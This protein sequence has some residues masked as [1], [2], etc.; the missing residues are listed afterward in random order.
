MGIGKTLEEAMYKGLTAAGYKLE[1]GG[2]VLFTVRDDDKPEIVEVAKRY[3]VLGFTIYAT[4]GTGAVLSRAGLQPIV[5]HKINEA[6]DNVIT[7]MESGKARYVVSTSKR[8]RDPARES[9]QL[10]ALATRL[11]IPCLTSIDT[12]MAV[13]DSLKSR[14]SEQNIELVN[15]NDMRGERK[16]LRFSKMHSCGKDDLY[17]DCLGGTGQSISSPESLSIMLVDRNYGVGGH[18]VVLICDSRI[19]DARMRLFNTDG[20]EGLMSASAVACVG[21]HLYEKGLVRNPKSI[22]V[23][24]QSGVRRLALN[25][26][27]GVAVSG[28]VNLGTPNFSPQS[29][30]VNLPGEKILGRVVDTGDG[31][32]SITCVSMGSPHCV[33]FCDDVENARVEAIGPK[34]ELAPIFPKRSNVEFVQVLDEN[35]LKMR[36]WERG[37]G[38]T[39]ASGSGAC[40]SVVAAVENGFCAR[41]LPVRVIKNGGEMTVDYTGSDVILDCKVH[42]VFEGEVEI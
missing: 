40:A 21:K 12:A 42:K 17:F 4:K 15:I 7:L 28:K 8:G 5:I 34:I 10:R 30:P 13:A 16:T 24:T 23:E 31:I 26:R 36:I 39:P 38:E 19:A 20:S 3:A 25:T 18:G 9:A 11:G 14:Y 33:M 37:D 2:G 27:Y 32:F 6:S 41:R 22:T 1:R 29:I 35:T